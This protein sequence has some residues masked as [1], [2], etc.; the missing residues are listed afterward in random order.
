MAGVDLAPV[1]AFARRLFEER[2][3]NG[4]ELRRALA[5]QFPDLDAAALAYACRNHLA[6]VQV[7]PRGVWGKS[8]QVTL[9][10]AEAWLGRPVAAAPSMAEV[11]MRYFAAYGPASVADVAAWTRLTGLRPVVEALRPR[12]RVFRTEAGRELFDVPDAPRPSP[13]TP[14]PPRLLPE[15][16]NV[17]LSHADRSRFGTKDVWARVGAAGPVKG[18]VLHDGTVAATWRIEAGTLVVHHA[19]LP[20]AATAEIEDEGRRYVEF[21]GGQDVRFISV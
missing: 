8:A 4:N 16:D 6:L 9:T 13:D 5:A 11:V 10:T 15:Y 20:R 21:A 17:L 14:A 3:R 19:A 18:T 1:L 12:L 2:P 7:P